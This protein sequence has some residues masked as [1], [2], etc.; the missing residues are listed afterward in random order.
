MSET[1]NMYESGQKSVCE[2]AKCAY[3]MCMG[4]CVQVCVRVHMYEYVKVLF[5]HPNKAA[6]LECVW[7][8]PALMVLLVLLVDN[9]R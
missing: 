2:S 3:R 5:V 8:Q 6:G 4:V 9:S 1:V 7:S